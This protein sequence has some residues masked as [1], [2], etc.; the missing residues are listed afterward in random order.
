MKATNTNGQLNRLKSR[1][2]NHCYIRVP[3]SGGERTIYLDNLPDLSD[4]KSASYS[5]E[6][7]PGRS[8]PFKTFV[9]GENRVISMT[10][11]FFVSKAGDA[12]ENLEKIRLLQS[13]LYPDHLYMAYSPPP[14]CSIRCGDLLATRELCV[15][16]KSCNVRYPTEYV[17]DERTF[18]PIKVDVE[19]SWEVVY[20]SR[21]LPGQD[22]IMDFGG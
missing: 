20:Q 6:S 21:N 4:S 3:T 9:S 8:F 16:M 12:Q 10:V 13:C 7:V 22:R 2:G 5:D 19:L 15:I 17:W 14:I 11:H 1:T 18:C